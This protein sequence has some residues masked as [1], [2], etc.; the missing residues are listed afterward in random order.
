MPTPSAPSSNFA[1]ALATFLERFPVPA[2]HMVSSYAPDES[3]EARAYSGCWFTLTGAYGTENRVVFRTAKVTPTK[4][5]LFVTLWK[6]DDSGITRPYSVE[7][8]VDEFWVVTETPN[9]YGYFAFTAQSLVDFGRI[10]FVRETREARIPS[11]HT[12]GYG[13]QRERNQGMGLAKK[14]LHRAGAIVFLPWKNSR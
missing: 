12:L 14:V 13:T 5:G 4:A 1:P 7:D 3:P 8:G 11:L 6:R 2:G 9:G 10:G